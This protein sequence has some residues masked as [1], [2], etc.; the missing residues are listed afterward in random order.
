MVYCII[1]ISVCVDYLCCPKNKVHVTS[2]GQ[3]F[4]NITCIAV[5]VIG[6]PKLLIAGTRINFGGLEPGLQKIEYV[7]SSK[8]HVI[9]QNTTAVFD[10]LPN[11]S[12]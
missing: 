10:K 9:P 3:G 11:A 4:E 2:K 12:S 1:D 5:S 7:G 8:F 6:I